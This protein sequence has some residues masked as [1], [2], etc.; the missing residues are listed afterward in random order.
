MSLVRSIA[1]LNVCVAGFESRSTLKKF[2]AAVEPQRPVQSTVS[3]DPA[4]TTPDSALLWSKAPPDVTA[5]EPFVVPCAPPIEAKPVAQTAPMTIPTAAN[6]SQAAILRRLRRAVRA[7]F[8]CIASPAFQRPRP[9][10]RHVV[11][12]ALIGIW[13]RRA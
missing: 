9:C 4:V 8:S 2:V 12:A 1:A 3:G 7:V 10:G 6:A 5:G 13:G 11:L